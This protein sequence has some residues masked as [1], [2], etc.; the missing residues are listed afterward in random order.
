M[1]EVALQPQGTSAVVDREA[2]AGFAVFTNRHSIVMASASYLSMRARTA[3]CADGVQ[4]RVFFKA[5]DV[6]CPSAHRRQCVSP[7]G[8]SVAS[9]SLK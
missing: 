1:R 4:K 6:V 2:E 8:I 7:P 5:G 9:R 3:A